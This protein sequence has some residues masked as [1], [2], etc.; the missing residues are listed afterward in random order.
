MTIVRLAR[1]AYD[2]C[3]RFHPDGRRGYG[4]QMAAT[5]DALVASARA[6][7]RWAVLTVAI[8]ECAG[9]LRAAWTERRRSDV[10]DHSG[11]RPMRVSAFWQDVRFASRTFRRRPGF[12]AAVIVTLGLGIGATTAIFSLIDALV[13]QRLPFPDPDRLVMVWEDASTLGFPRNTPSP[14]NYA[15]WT[16][17]IPALGGVA[18]LDERDFNLTGDGDPEKIGGAGVTAN[19]FSVLDV[20]PMIGRLWRADEDIPGN[21]IAI[22]SYA[23]WQRRFAGDPHALDRQV[24]LNGAPYTVLGVMP[25]RFEIVSPDLQIWTPMNFGATA[26]GDRGDHYLWVVGRMAAG[27]TLEDVNLQLRTLATRLQHDAPDTNRNLGMYAV[28]LLDDYLGDT[29]LALV[30]LAAAVGVV[31][32]IA[33]GNVANLLLAR[34]ADRIRETA[35]RAALG[36]GRGRLIRQLL[37]ESLVLA[38]AGGVTGLAIA[39]LSFSTLS[40]LVPA[41]L[42]GARHVALDWRVLSMAAAVSCATALLFGVIPAC[43]ASRVDLS[44]SGGLMG[45]RGA[46]TGPTRFGRGLVVGEIALATVLLIGAGLIA[47]SFSA[48]RHLNLG[49]VPDGVLTARLQLPRKTY[50]DPDRR[51]AFVTAVLDRVRSL[52]GVSMAGYTSAAPLSWKGGTSGFRPEAQPADH[53]LPYDAVN[54]VITPGYMETIGMTLRSGRF[55]DDRDSDRGVPVAIVNER[56]ARQYWPGVD[57]I[58]RRFRA[59]SEGANAPIRTIVGI[60]GDTYPLGLDQPQHPE[61]FFPLAQSGTNWMWPRDLAIRTSADPASMAAAI[62]QA[63]RAVD[64]AEPIS[65]VRPLSDIVG[66]ELESR[67]TQATLMSAFAGLALV[68]A[69]VGIYGVLSYSVTSRTAEIGI[70]L[71][72]GGD[73][74]RIRRLV[75]RQGLMLAGFGLAIGLVAAIYASGWLAPLLFHVPAR[76]PE[77]F[78]VQTAVLLVVCLAAV[79]LPA[80]RASRVDPLKALR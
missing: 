43:R 74:G 54:R 63:V 80:W 35:T 30:L 39:V 1:A 23:L 56:M 15:D 21:R 45:S 71:A 76:D 79:Y 5:F 73:P 41:P 16:H 44:A 12:A 78:V 10:A 6:R 36:A 68:L 25:P 4:P 52:P 18:A 49:F 24:M 72:L 66:E 38:M 77:I 57:A 40:H 20:S 26:L 7:G 14:G 3:L 61:M 37:T 13:L 34:A 27:R 51:L 11:V 55:F 64:P 29:G 31:L 67:R 22:I 8:R 46:M 33:C 53:S 75:V 32:L 65:N 9:L 48:Q 58:G 70:R 17:A 2:A 19:L 60:V 50:A 42:A 28:P 69:A 47:G 62:R 59:G